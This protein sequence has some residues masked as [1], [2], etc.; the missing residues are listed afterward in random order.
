MPFIPHTDEQQKAMLKEIGLSDMEQ[1]FQDIPPELRT[2]PDSTIEAGKSEHEVRRLFQQLSCRNA[3][4]KTCFLG[5]GF[6]D[7]FIPAAVD[8]IISRSEFYTAYTP[9]QP[10]LSQGTLQAIFEYQTAIC[11]LTGMEAANASL[12][13]GGTALF[14]ALSMALNI[15]DKT[16][17]LVDEAVNPVYRKM[18]RSYTAN[19]EI[20]YKEIPAVDG[21]VN[22][23]QILAEL[24]DQTA[25]LILQN[26]N[27]FGIVDDFTDLVEKAHSVGAI[28]ICSIYP[29]ALGLLKTPG[30]MGFDIVTGEGQSLGLPLSFGGPYLGVIATLKKHVRKMPGRIA[31]MTRDTEG[32]R[33]FVL[34][35]QAREQHIRREKAISNICSN[36]AL[37]A[38][39]ALVYLTL[40]GKYGFTEAAETAAQ[41]AEYAYRKLT[42]IPGVTG[43]FNA[44]FYN[45]FV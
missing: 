10:E 37:C 3:V 36:Q 32:R 34:T 26:P 23:D 18:L 24:N 9:Y 19:L 42:E 11:R 16:K 14:E 31:G 7:H 4:E 13:D 15:T 17:V 21:M 40:L 5:G 44:P 35:L 38:L 45:E 20:D 28:S 22:R 2:S 25:A 41:N 12:Y 8:T 30:E 33:G 27:F 39:G 43:K 29:F 6:Y 1:L